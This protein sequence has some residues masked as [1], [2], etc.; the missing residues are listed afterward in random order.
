[1]WLHAAKYSLFWGIV[2]LKNT[3]LKITALKNFASKNGSTTHKQHRNKAAH[4]F[5]I[6]EDTA[7]GGIF[8]L[9]VDE[10]SDNGSTHFWVRFCARFFGPLGRKLPGVKRLGTMRIGQSW[11]G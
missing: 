2:A 10:S 4:L 6:A 11:D 8:L 7:S 1:M 9:L 5:H 3:A